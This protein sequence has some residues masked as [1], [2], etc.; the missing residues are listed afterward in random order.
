MANKLMAQ[1]T[2][3]WATVCWNLLHLVT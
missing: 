1:A 2:Y 3:L